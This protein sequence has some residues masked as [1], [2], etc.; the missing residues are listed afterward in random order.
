MKLVRARIREFLQ[1]KAA[2]V[3]ALV[4]TAYSLHALVIDTFFSPRTNVLP[5]KALLTFMVFWLM[6]VLWIA[7]RRY[8]QVAITD[9]ELEDIITGINPDAFIVVSPERRIVMCNPAVEKMFGFEPEDLLGKTTEKLYFDRRAPDGKDHVIHDQ[10]DRLGFHLGHATG[11][12]RNG[13]IIPLEIITGTIRGRRGAVLLLRDITKRVEAEKASREKADLVEKLQQ[14][15][16]KLRETEE[17]RDNI[18]HMIVHDMKNP[19]QVVLGTMQLLKEEMKSGSRDTIESYVDET[20]SHTRRLIDMVNSLLDVSRLESGEMPLRL[21]ACDLRVSAKRAFAS[22]ARIANGRAA[23]VYVPADPVPVTCDSE[24][25]HRVLTNLISN[26]LYHTPEESRI[27]ITVTPGENNARVEV[28]DNGPGIP[29][30]YHERI[31]SK[32]A[33]VDGPHNSTH[34]WS[35]GLGLTFCKLAVEAHGGKIG[36]ESET[37]KGS[38]FWFT[39]PWHPASSQIETLASTDSSSSLPG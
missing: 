10:L 24:I 8:C 12:H 35:T 5:P 4:L 7:Y 23:Q 21:G 22:L 28:T 29:K 2:I 9:R 25:I 14:N 19:L 6:A 27:M 33:H 26:A 13:S 38:T 36:V 32:F 1:L 18:L 30:E 11:K 3:L 20:L 31:F 34:H 16:T 39:L 15:Y 17:A 37:G